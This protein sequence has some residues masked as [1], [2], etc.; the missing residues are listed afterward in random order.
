[1]F[2]NLNLEMALITVLIVVIAIAFGIKTFMKLKEK[3]KGFA[4]EDERS[5]KVKLIAGA[6]SFQASIW[7]LLILMWVVNVFGILKIGM[8]QIFGVAILGMGLIFGVYWLII[9]KKENLDMY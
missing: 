9:N 4:T 7:Y 8:E 2:E 3:K 6:K 1:M 5:R